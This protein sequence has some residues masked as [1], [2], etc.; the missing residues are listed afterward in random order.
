MRKSVVFFSLLLLVA[1]VVSAC[2]GGAAPATQAPAPAQ[3]QPTTA[4]AAPAGEKVKLTIESWRNDDLKIW[5]DSIIPAFEKSNP[6]IHVVFAPTAPTEYN[7]ALN[8]KLTGGTAG[9]LGARVALFAL[10]NRKVSAAAHDG[11]HIAEGRRF[12]L[13]LFDVLLHV[14]KSLKVGRHEFLRVGVGEPGR[15][16]QSECAL[17]IS[18]PKVDSFGDAALVGCYLCQ[19]DTEN[20]RGGGRVNVF[21]ARKGVSQAWVAAQ[22]RQDAEFDL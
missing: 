15:L 10:E 11:L 20:R 14:G 4:P 16:C 19:R 8:T 2:G 7:A 21:A 12:M 6:N 17:S 22:V 5:S 18:Q 1:L 13:G 9:D 3:G